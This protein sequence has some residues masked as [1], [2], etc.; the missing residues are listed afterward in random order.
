MVNQAIRPDKSFAN[1]SAFIKEK[2]ET[3]TGPTAEEK[4]LGGGATGTFWI[5]LKSY[6]EETMKELDDINEKAIS[7]GANFEEVGRNTIVIN[8][9]KGIIKKVID[10]VEDSE[11]AL[12]QSS[13]PAR[14]G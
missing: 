3:E 11:E 13:K 7:T 12:E 6:I 14:K 1:I 4:I 2:E 10:R 5:T 8:L 9:A